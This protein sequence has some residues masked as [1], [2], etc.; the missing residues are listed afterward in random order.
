[1]PQES[2]FE[3][4]ILRNITIVSMSLISNQNHH[5]FSAHHMTSPLPLSHPKEEIHLIKHYASNQS[6]ARDSTIFQ[7]SS[8]S[9]HPHSIFLYPPAPLN[10]NMGLSAFKSFLR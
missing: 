7:A 6:A 4:T 9:Y 3:Y 10:I 8:Q 5:P 1:M 2:R